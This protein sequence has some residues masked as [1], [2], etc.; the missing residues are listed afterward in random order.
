MR[1]PV[2]GTFPRIQCFAATLIFTLVIVPA[3][4]AQTQSTTGTIQGDVVDANGAA[5][6]GANVEIRNLDTNAIRN[7][8]TDEA[9]RFTALALQPGN[10]F[11]SVSKQG[12]ATAQIPSATL[13]VGQALA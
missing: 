11:I 5:V 9:G 12:F 6:P 1:T 13:T 10:Y 3:I 2:L 7:L 8:T 4:V